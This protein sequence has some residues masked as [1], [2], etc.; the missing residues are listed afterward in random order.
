[1]LAETE[2]TCFRVITDISPQYP[3]QPLEIDKVL[4][5]SEETLLH[6]DECLFNILYDTPGSGQFQLHL[7]SIRR[8]RPF[9][10]SATRVT[11]RE[12]ETRAD[13]Y[14]RRRHLSPMALPLYNEDFAISGLT[15]RLRDQVL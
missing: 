5:F 2:R 7:R 12:D 15:S 13:S 1:M 4:S 14:Y 6:P 10:S 11:Q 8:R 3:H 9:D